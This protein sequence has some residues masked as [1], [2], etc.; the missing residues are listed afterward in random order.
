VKTTPGGTQKVVEIKARHVHSE[1]N[2]SPATRKPDIK[3]NLDQ[4]KRQLVELEKA[5]QVGP[6]TKGTVLRVIHDSDRGASSARELAVWRKEA[7]DVRQDWIDE[8][9]DPDE[10]ALRSRVHVTTTTRSSYTRATKNL[11]AKQLKASAEALWQSARRGGKV[12]LETAVHGT[13][14]SLPLIGSALDAQ[15]VVINCIGPQRSTDGCA[16]AVVSAVPGV[17]DIYS[18]AKVVGSGLRALVDIA[19]THGPGALIPSGFATQLAVHGGYRGML[20]SPIDLQ[21]DIQSR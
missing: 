10:K 15:D 16:D 12:V 14:K 20:R 2:E 13:L 19:E 4:N 11:R 18:G 9:T 8:A 6:Q 17:G 7:N 5:G 3:A 1:R 21:K